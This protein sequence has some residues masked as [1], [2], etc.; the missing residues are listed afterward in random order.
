MKPILQ[1]IL[2]G[3]CI[4]LLFLSTTNTIFAHSTLTLNCSTTNKN[5]N[6]NYSPSK[7]TALSFIID[8]PSQ[9]KNSPAVAATGSGCTFAQHPIS[10]TTCEGTST[11]FTIAT[12]SGFTAPIFYE[13]QVSTDGSYFRTIY[14]NNNYHHTGTSTLSIDDVTSLDGYEYRVLAT[15]SGCSAVS[16]A[17]T[18]TVQPQP[19]GQNTSQK[20]CSDEYVSL[21]FQDYIHNNISSHFN[22]QVQQISSELTGLEYQQSGTGNLSTVLHNNSTSVQTATIIIYPTA[23]TSNCVGDPFTVE[24]KVYPNQL[25]AISGAKKVCSG[26]VYT[27]IMEDI[28]LQYNWRVNGG[29]I[30]SDT[31]KNTLDI[32]WSAGASGDYTLT[33][34]VVLPGNCYQE[35][36]IAVNVQSP[37]RVDI[38]TTD[39]SCFGANDGVA[40]IALSGATPPDD[41]EIYWSNLATTAT[42]AQL[43]P[44]DYVAQ[45]ITP[46]GCVV[47]DVVTIH[48]PSPL[49]IVATVQDATCPSIS[50]GS[51]SVQVD[52]GTGTYRYQWMDNNNNLISQDAK[53]QNIAGGQYTLIVTDSNN[54]EFTENYMVNDE[55]LVAPVVECHASTMEYALDN[56]G[57]V[58][59]NANTFIAN[60]TDNCGIA[61]ITFA[62]QQSTKVFDCT[63]V[64]QQSLTVIVS[65]DNGNQTTCQKTITITDNTNPVI[66]CSN[67]FLERSL[68]NDGIVRLSIHRIINCEI[69]VIM[70]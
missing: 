16:N 47:G 7:N 12:G 25:P 67:N 53:L 22:W 1:Y 3:V 15:G 34:G 24:L 59:L 63:Q 30:I 61:T 9:T 51:I 26:N 48:E 11:Q 52:G 21:N 33:V 35:K 36:Q 31:D 66:N 37:P 27:Y 2:K 44:N 32:K 39:I 69:I 4:L 6:N 14:D 41:I 65:D 56:N 54:C 5:T 28:G 42:I 43:T 55:D 64:G 57:T 23:Q 46:N 62:N 19:Q 29:I 38:S 68:D 58:V 60:A 17:A 10:V 50:D 49:D 18:L 20:T 45:V 40:T 8:T 13:W 70:C